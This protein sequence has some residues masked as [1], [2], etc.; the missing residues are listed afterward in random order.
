MPEHE[1]WY[2]LTKGPWHICGCGHAR[3]S[4]GQ[5]NDKEWRELE[6][7]RREDARRI[8]GD[9]PAPDAP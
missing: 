8:Q 1:H 9:P 4:R 5:L 2:F 7:A 3:P 6:N